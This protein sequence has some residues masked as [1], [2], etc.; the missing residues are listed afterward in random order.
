MT[1]EMISK[2]KECKSAEELL[3]LAKENNVEMT[4]AQAAELL[5]KLNQEGELSD[6]ELD[7]AAGGGCGS[8]DA[9]LL[10]NGDVV[11]TLD[12]FCCKC[13]CNVFSVRW[14]QG[15]GAWFYCRDCG[16]EHVVEYTHID[17]VKVER[18]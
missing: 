5:A 7:G 8:D 14:M 18:A 12:G 10:K 11:R 17:G 15:W 4:E 13:G 9:N 2:A 16:K 3:A 6:D 1:S